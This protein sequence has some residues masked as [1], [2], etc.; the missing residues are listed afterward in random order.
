MPNWRNELHGVPPGGLVSLHMTA[1]V[2]RVQ[3][4]GTRARRCRLWR[5]VVRR[6]SAVQ[7]GLH[8]HT[9][10]ANHLEAGILTPR[11]RRRLTRSW[12]DNDF[13]DLH[14]RLHCVPPCT[15]MATSYNLYCTH[16]IISTPSKHFLPPSATS[17]QLRVLLHPV[18]AV[19]LVR[20]SDRCSSPFPLLT[21]AIHWRI[22]TGDCTSSAT[23][24]PAFHPHQVAHLHPS[25]GTGR[26]SSGIWLHPGSVL[27]S[28]R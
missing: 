27:L 12:N 16:S 20:E 4:L 7:E 18:A 28:G 13:I 25:N 23:N 17:H 3:G 11:D 6:D 22:V 10:D 2:A 5:H 9:L 14:W 8:E 26:L 15:A 21:S 19:N 24:R 1:L